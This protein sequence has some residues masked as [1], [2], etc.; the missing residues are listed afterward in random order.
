MHTIIRI[1]NGKC[2]AHTSIKSARTIL[3]KSASAFCL[4]GD[5]TPRPLSKG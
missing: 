3:H 2:L 5:A 1:S 4:D